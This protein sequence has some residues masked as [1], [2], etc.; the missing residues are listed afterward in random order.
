MLQ[1]LWSKLDGRAEERCGF[2]LSDGSIVELD[3]IHP[4]PTAGFMVSADTVAAYIDEI[5]ATWHTHPKTSS[6]LSGEDYQTFLNY[7]WCEHFV[8]GPDGV[9][10]YIVKDGAVIE[11][12]HTPRPTEETAS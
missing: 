5:K 1:E 12:G 8:I 4:E 10:S 3:N 9:R 11:E 2:I 6:L 7:E